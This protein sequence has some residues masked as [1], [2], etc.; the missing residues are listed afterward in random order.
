MKRWVRL[1]ELAEYMGVSV[2]TVRN[3]CKKGLITYKVPGSNL[4]YVDSADLQKFLVP[5]N[6]KDEADRMNAQIREIVKTLSKG[7]GQ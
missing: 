5:V 7:G 3:W 6:A 4:V 2:R 1:K